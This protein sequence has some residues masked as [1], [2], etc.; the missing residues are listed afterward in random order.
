LAMPHYLIQ[1][2]YGDKSVADMVKSPQ[3]RAAIV[4]TLVEKLG[5][6]LQSFYFAFGD[7]DGAAIAEFPDNVTAAALSM[8]V[9]S[10]GSFRSFKTTV[11]ISPDD[12]VK[13]MRK[14]AETTSAYRPPGK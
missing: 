7:Y 4:R 1:W 14:A 2:S 10:A 8:V 3:D 6:K 12:S 13:A 11:L 5:G 9:T